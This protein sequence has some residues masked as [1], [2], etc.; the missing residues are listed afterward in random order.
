M[1][2]VNRPTVEAKL[3]SRANVYARINVLLFWLNGWRTGKKIFW[4]LDFFSATI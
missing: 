1:A 3:L 2:P 4:P